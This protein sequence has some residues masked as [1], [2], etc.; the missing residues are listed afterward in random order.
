PTAY[1]LMAP[2]EWDKIP[3]ICVTLGA[4][5]IW[6]INNTTHELHNFHLHQSKFRLARPGE[7]QAIGVQETPVVDPTHQLDGLLSEEA[8]EA[9]NVTIWHDTLPVPQAKDSVHP[10]KI[11]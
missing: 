9:S 5:E 1:P 7:L 8:G 11:F 4:S 2:F 3:H 6:E 10:G